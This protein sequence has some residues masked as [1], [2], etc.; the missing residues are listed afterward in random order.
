PKFAAG[1]N[2]L[3]ALLCDDLKEYDKA[4]ECFRTAMKLDR[5]NAQTRGNLSVALGNKG[6]TLVNSPD[7][8]LRDP[9][10]AIEAV[11]EAVKLTPRSVVAWQNLGWV[12]YRIGNWRAS[13]EALEKSCKLQAGGTGYP[14]Q[15]IVLAL[16]HARLAAQESL[17]EK[18]RAHHQAEAR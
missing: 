6:W 1:H 14:S 18:E 15:W 2:S 17:P 12:Q 13:I 8:K 10:R 5:N 9:K 16:A 4:I 7:P 11:H 3:G